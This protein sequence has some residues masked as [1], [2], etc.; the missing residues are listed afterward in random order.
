M[1]SKFEED[2]N[3]VRSQKQ[4]CVNDPTGRLG[5]LPGAPKY[6]NIHTAGTVG[7]ALV[8]TM[9]G[10]S[11]IVSGYLGQYG[12]ATGQMNYAALG[13]NA[14]SGATYFPPN[15]FIGDTNPDDV[16]QVNMD[17]KPQYETDEE[18]FQFHVSHDFG[19]LQLYY[20]GGYS[21]TSV[22]SMEDYTKGVANADWSDALNAMAALS[23]VPALPG[24][25]AP[26]IAAAVAQYGP[27]AQALVPL[28]ITDA[29]TG[30]PGV[31]LWVGNP[32]LA[33]LGN[34]VPVL[35]P[36][37]QSY[38]YAFSGD[39]YDESSNDNKQWTHEIRLQSSFDGPLNFLAG[40]FYL[41]FDNTN[42]YIV[43]AS[44]LALPGQHLLI[45]PRVYPAP[46]G[47]PDN[48]RSES[49]PY[50]QGYHNDSRVYKLD[51]KAIFGEVYWDVTDSLR[52]T[53]GG[54]YTEEK[55]EG[56]QRTIYVTFADL[57]S[58]QPNNAFFEPVFEQE[59]FSWKVNATW[60]MSD[61]TMMYAT[62]SSSFK[63]GGFNPISENSPVLT[64]ALGG[65]PD[66]AYFDPEFID[67]YEIGLKTTL[68]GGAMQ[69]NAAGFYYDYA[70][71]QQSQIV[72]VTSKNVNAD[73]EITGIE[74]DVLWAITPNLI[75]SFSGG[76]LDTEI[77]EFWS[78][79]TAN[80]YAATQAEL[81][82]DPMSALSPAA[83]QGDGTALVSINGANSIAGVDE[84]G[85][86][87]RC[88]TQAPNPCYGY[89][90]NQKGNQIAGSPELNYNIGL[91]W[92]L[93]LGSMDLTLSTNY[94]WQDE[95]YAS[96]FNNISNKV[97]DWSMWNASA[98][99]SGER[100]YAE[101]WVKNIED[102]DNVTGH[103]LTAAI[104]G[105][106]TNQFILDPQTYGVSVGYQ[107]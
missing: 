11:T 63:S 36:D 30:M 65:N 71:F 59:E 23:T 6:E 88:E 18:T 38:Y 15:D 21:E 69:V 99:V 12:L 106:F 45:D 2:D 57:P 32:T 27:T 87:G 20:D 16:R 80:P 51:A 31:G 94:Y 82:A 98:R 37:D 28:L 96:N 55:K 42:A 10:L 39:G 44:G 53:F 76:W 17:F 43:R 66:D 103:Y 52:L 104:S 67:A 68:F 73:A 95:F 19:D 74:L 62:V 35:G 33:G 102:N 91:A 41:D 25:M 40:G 86:R 97:D 14:A 13:A 9:G 70:D 101:A 34:G 107:F 58:V 93:P 64:P 79:D 5:C 92:T 85:T 24:A 46:Y 8:N 89:M 81:A 48:P 75:A 29:A 1:Y 61:N 72:N 60:N 83:A 26:D 84:A 22:T 50:M 78:V 90:Q 7:G 47:D 4:A 56:K 54:R 100:W 77:G 49:N 3:R 105:L